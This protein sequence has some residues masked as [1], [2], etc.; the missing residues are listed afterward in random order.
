TVRSSTANLLNL[1]GALA[2]SPGEAGPSKDVAGAMY[3]NGFTQTSDP[4]CGRVTA[5]QT[6]NTL[7]TN[8]AIKDASG[9]LILVNPDPGQLGN[10]GKRWIEGPTNFQ[11]DFDLVK[12][13][14]IA[15][16]KEFELRVD[17]I[18][19]LNHSVWGNPTLDINSANFGRI[20]TKTGNRT[21]TI[22]TRLNF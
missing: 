19:V 21:F 20:T 22:N 7:C 10:L 1:V 15:E 5:A 9:N 6:L 16:R 3:F 4:S 14:K 17:A 8:L 13:I 2:K 18:N 11:L 12:R